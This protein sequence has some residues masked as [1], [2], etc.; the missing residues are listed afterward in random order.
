MKYR[1]GFK[2][3]LEEDMSVKTDIKPE[4]R[5]KYA[6][7]GHNLITL[8]VGGKLT[9]H[10]GYASDLAS[11]P[12]FNTKSTRRG[13]VFHDAIYELLR[14][15]LLNQEWIIT[16]DKML[17]DICK[18]DGMYS[19]RAWYWYKG[20]RLANGSAANPDNIKEIFEAP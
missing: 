18:D 10:A 15:R 3:Q 17:I 7:H 6:R 9:V 4:R 19:W 14:Q 13:A 8:A 5:I 2:I 1:K 20:L 12:T 16:A 11:G